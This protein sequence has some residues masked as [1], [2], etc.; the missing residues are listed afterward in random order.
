[1]KDKS[2]V[3]KLEELARTLR[4]TLGVYLNRHINCHRDA[5]INFSS[6]GMTLCYKKTSIQTSFEQVKS[7]LHL[8]QLIIGNAINV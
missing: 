7:Y 1:M 2:K 3:V 5:F 6:Q 8:R 4:G